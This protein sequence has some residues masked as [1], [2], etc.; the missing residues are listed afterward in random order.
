MMYLLD[1][2]PGIS[3][4]MT[5]SIVAFLL[6]IVALVA[7]LLYAKAKLLP[8]GEVKLTINEET[9]MTVQ[10]GSTI[11]SALSGN[12]IFLPST[13]THQKSIK[14]VGGRAWHRPS[15]FTQ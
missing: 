2:T 15:G 8:S 12:K 3:S 4:V 14:K 5:F 1:A 13:T 7:I 10:P 11:L 9:E 6:I